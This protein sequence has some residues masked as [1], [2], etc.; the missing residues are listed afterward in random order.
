M[1]GK[2]ELLRA[3]AFFGQLIVHIKKYQSKLKTAHFQTTKYSISGAYWRDLVEKQPEAN[4]PKFLNTSSD[5]GLRFRFYHIFG[6]ISYETTASFAS[7]WV[8]K[9][10]LLGKPNERD[11]TQVEFYRINCDFNSLSKVSWKFEAKQLAQFC[12]PNEKFHTSQKRAG[13]NWSAIDAAAILVQKV[14]DIYKNWKN[15]RV[16][17]MDVE[18][19]FDH[20]SWVKLTQKMAD[21]GDD[22]EFVG[23][24]QSFLTH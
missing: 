14:Q 10:I 20:E 18:S 2:K 23:W 11:C 3:N 8:T 13:L 4:I 5:I 7:M 21:L 12:E 16:F 15:A 22:D 19:E 6:Y 9:I 24:N 17:L 1:Q